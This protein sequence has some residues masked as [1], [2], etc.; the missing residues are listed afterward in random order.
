M[1]KYN[2]IL[3]PAV[4]VTVTGYSNMFRMDRMDNEPE[5]KMEAHGTILRTL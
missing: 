2:I 5:L 3:A 1:S 4:G